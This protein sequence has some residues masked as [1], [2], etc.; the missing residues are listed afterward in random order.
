MHPQRHSPFETWQADVMRTLV[1]AGP[2]ATSYF[3][4]TERH[5]ESLRMAR[6][7]QRHGGAV[8]GSARWLLLATFSQGWR[9]MG[10][11]IA[12]GFSSIRPRPMPRRSAAD[13][14]AAP[15]P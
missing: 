14:A 4:A 10:Q 11:V 2:L 15:M 13:A 9:K 1:D 7:M 5:E 3:A 6:Q 8:K 12:T